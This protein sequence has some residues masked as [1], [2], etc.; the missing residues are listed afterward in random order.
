MGESTTNPVSPLGKTLP[1]QLFLVNGCSAKLGKM[2][3][4][5]IKKMN[6]KTIALEELRMGFERFVRSIN[7]ITFKQFITKMNERIHIW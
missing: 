2:N 1:W 7:Y 6:Q 5:D 4:V 3:T